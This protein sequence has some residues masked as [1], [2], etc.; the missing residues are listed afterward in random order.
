M[1]RE[2][3]FMEEIWALNPFLRGCPILSESIKAKF[4]KG[5]YDTV[6]LAKRATEL[7]PPDSVERIAVL[8]ELL[9]DMGDLMVNILQILRNHPDPD[10]QGLMARI[11]ETLGG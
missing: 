9:Q 7:S 8:E 10:I 6:A 11:E 2:D 3:Q 4:E 5:D 1:N